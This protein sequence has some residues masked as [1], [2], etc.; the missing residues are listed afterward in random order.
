LSLEQFLA[1]MDEAKALL[2]LALR[3][4]NL[5]SEYVAGLLFTTF[6]AARTES[7]LR[8][9]VAPLLGAKAWGIQRSDF[10]IRCSIQQAGRESQRT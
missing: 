8:A 7:T 1:K 5:Q 4:E 10:L 3:S 2:C 6:A 9:E